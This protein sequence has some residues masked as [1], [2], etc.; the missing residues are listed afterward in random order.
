VPGAQPIHFRQQNFDY[1]E[2]KGKAK[3]L[4]FFLC[5]R[6][7]DSTS[8][9]NVSVD[10]FLKSLKWSS[11]FPLRISMKNFHYGGSADLGK[12]CL[13]CHTEIAWSPAR[14]PPK[15]GFTF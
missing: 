11:D 7:L 5:M 14:R 2:K 13:L 15:Q 8:A 3:S 1:V 12:L 9:I 4:P 10:S 6:A